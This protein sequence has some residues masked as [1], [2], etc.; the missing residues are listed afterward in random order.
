MQMGSLLDWHQGQGGK[1]R[2]GAN[3]PA[4]VIVAHEHA[5]LCGVVRHA[6]SKSVTNM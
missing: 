2:N 4:V 6:G 3:L 1:Q 5:H